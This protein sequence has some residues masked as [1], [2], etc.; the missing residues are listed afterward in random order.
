MITYVFNALNRNIRGLTINE[1]AAIVLEIHEAEIMSEKDYNCVES[2][3]N[4]P[5]SVSD[6][7]AGA[8]VQSLVGRNYIAS[9]Y[10]DLNTDAYA[11]TSKGCRLVKIV[12]AQR[13]YIQQLINV[14]HTREELKRLQAVVDNQARHAL[15]NSPAAT[16]IYEA[17]GTGFNNSKYMALAMLREEYDVPSTVALIDR[18]ILRPLIKNRLVS[19]AVG[20]PKVLDKGRAELWTL[21]WT[22]TNP[23]YDSIVEKVLLDNKDG[24]YADVFEILRGILQYQKRHPEITTEIN[25][26]TLNSLASLKL[27]AL[28]LLDKTGVTLTQRGK[29][30]LET[31]KQ[32]D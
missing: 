6:M 22:I 20:S 10:I 25:F 30:L 24:G 17:L 14:Q 15:L 16:M 12:N 1:I 13:E 8:D 23:D 31:V 32:L 27:R 11:L 2:L 9:I 19:K 4:G 26:R 5:R 3:M 21:E 7:G 29:A 18:D 28:G